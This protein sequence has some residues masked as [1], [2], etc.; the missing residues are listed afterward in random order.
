M[1]GIKIQTLRESYQIFKV[2]YNPES[3]LNILAWSYV[4]KKFRI[5]VDTA[6][7]NAIIVHVGE[8]GNQ[9]YG[10]GI[11]FLSIIESN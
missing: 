6:V 1:A 7:K 8:G 10:S 9:I 2:R 5:T 11:G 3:M 4:R